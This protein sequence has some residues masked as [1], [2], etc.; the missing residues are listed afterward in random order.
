ME[1]PKHPWEIKNIYLVRGLVP[2]GKQIFNSLKVAVKR[3]IK[4]FRFL[5]FHNEELEIDTSIL[6][7]KNI[8]AQCGFPRV[9]ISERDPKFT[10]DSWTNLYEILGTKLAFSKAYHPQSDRLAERMIHK[11]EEII[12]RFRAYGVE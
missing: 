4:A 3:C 2:G 8:I 9:I 5:P 11:M 12:T 10:S 7:Q 6:F 1:Y